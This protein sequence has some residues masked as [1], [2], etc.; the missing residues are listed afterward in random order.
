MSQKVNQVYEK[1]NPDKFDLSEYNKV[2]DYQYKS[3]KNA[4][5]LAV[6]Q[7]HSEYSKLIENKIFDKVNIIL[8]NFSKVF[9]LNYDLLPYWSTMSLSPEDRLVD[10]FTD[11]SNF[12]PYLLTWAEEKKR[13]QI[14]YL[15]GNICLYR[16]SIFENTNTYKKKSKGNLLCELEEIFKVGGFPLFV[17]EGKWEKKL[18]QIY[19]SSYLTFCLI[20]FRNIEHDLT[21]M[22]WSF[23]DEFDKHIIDSIS[24]N[25]LLKKIIVGIYPKNPDGTEKLQ[26]EIEKEKAYIKSKLHRANCVLEYFDSETFGD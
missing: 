2:L 23:S 1:Y 20:N 16:K 10:F 19:S 25:K 21:I 18:E 4:L 24:K 17:S 14:Y 13:K 6:R 9:T 15:H 12:E 7:N 11:K 3:I 8:S 26:E 22:G 5:I